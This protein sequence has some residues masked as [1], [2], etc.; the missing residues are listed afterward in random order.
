MRE[1]CGGVYIH[2]RNHVRISGIQVISTYLVTASI[3]AA[4]ECSG[5]YKSSY[6]G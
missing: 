4:W 3:M 5:S 2:D 1:E 6:W